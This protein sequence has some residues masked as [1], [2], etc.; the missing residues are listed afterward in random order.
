[1]V[2]RFWKG[3]SKLELTFYSIFLALLIGLTWPYFKSFQCRA[4][5]SEAISL[6]QDVH[7]LEA[8]LK[9]TENRYVPI[10]ELLRAGRFTSPRT[11]FILT[12]QVM[13]ENKYLIVAESDSSD[14]PGDKWSI[15][16]QQNIVHEYQGCL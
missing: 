4:M 9:S 11:R 16:E 13:A 14:I 5:Q 1:M 15:D 8:Y 2:K 3:T 10:E 7:K 6:L 12:T